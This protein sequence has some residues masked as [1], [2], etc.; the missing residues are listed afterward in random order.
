LDA[1]GAVRP[2]IVG[3][4]LLVIILIAAVALS[5]PDSN[6]STGT[7]SAASS[8][9]SSANTQSSAAT[10]S[11]ASSTAQLGI[12]LN[13]SINSSSIAEGQSLSVSISLTNAL[14]TINDIPTSNDW[15]FHGVSGE[16]WGACIGEYPLEVAILSGN[17]TAQELPSVANT[18]FEYTCAGYIQVSQVTFQPRSDEAN[19]TGTGPGP[20]LNQTL[21]PFD[22]ALNFTT[23]GYWDLKSLSKQTNPPLL[24]PGT[25]LNLASIKFVPGTYTVAV[26]DEWGQTAIQHFTVTD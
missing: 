24:G 11:T 5:R 1:R 14:P 2:V 18:T 17:Y 23:S 26:A 12:Q 19:I 9:I 22:L 8:A 10:S 16:V 3:A 20:G 13:E 4:V 25:T 6:S 15:S 21:G 7:S